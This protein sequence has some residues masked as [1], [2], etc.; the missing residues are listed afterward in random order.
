MSNNIKAYVNAAPPN[1]INKFDA[2]LEMCKQV[3]EKT[4]ATKFLVVCNELEF[5]SLKALAPVCEV[6]KDFTEFPDIAI[7]S[8]MFKFK[9]QLGENDVTFF[10]SDLPGTSD[11]IYVIPLIEESKYDEETSEETNESTAE[12]H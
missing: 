8:Y 10:N 9:C 2:I 5:M 4:N 6:V 3:K 7:T 12:D 1:D 11:L